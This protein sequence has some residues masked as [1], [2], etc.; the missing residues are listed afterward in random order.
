[1]NEPDKWWI[2]ISKAQWTVAAL[3][4]AVFLYGLLL[5]RNLW[6]SAGMFLGI[7]TILA[8]LLALKPK[9]RTV[10]GGILTGITL[11]LLIAAPLVGEGYLCILMASPLF[12][13]VGVIV[14]LAVDSER[15]SRKRI[16]GCLA[17]VLLP[18]CLEGVV[19]QW[20]FNRS[21][22]AEVTKVVPAGAE[23]VERALAGSLRVDTPLPRFLRI[24]FPRPLAARGEGMSAGDTRTIHFAGA[25][26]D[27]PGDLTL[28]VAERR[29]G[30]VRFVT[31]G[32]TSKLT[33]WL[34]WDGSEVQ[35]KMLDASHTAVTWRIHFH[36]QLDP[37]W[38]FTWLEQTA[39]RDAAAYL[40][41]ANATPPE[42]SR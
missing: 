16:L 40:I 39:V 8:I 29:G 14:G 24:G 9:A 38:Y 3:A 28:R 41:D 18:M 6:R 37:A 31:V 5:H 23:E 30:Y 35:W 20:A 25:E 1:M 22:S 4:A 11:A 12:Y 13:L 7:P 19:P 2:R 33:Q 27:P 21:Q 15:R 26:G 32:D 34:Q 42:A 10:T 17:V 36:R